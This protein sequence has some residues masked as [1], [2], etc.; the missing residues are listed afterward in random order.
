M[1]VGHWSFPKRYEGLMMEVRTT[2]NC[3]SVEL[4]CNGKVMGI[5]RTSD[6]D[7]HTIS[8]HMPYTPGTLE[9]RAYRDGKVVATKKMVTARKATKIVVNADRTHLKADGQDLAFLKITLTDDAGNPV[10]VDDRDITVEVSG[11]GRLRGIDTGET[12]RKE[13]LCSPTTSSFFGR[14]QAVVQATRQP[15][16][17]SVVVKAGGIEKSTTINLLTR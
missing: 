2:T 7:N 10:E 14:A 1:M 3:D 4:V 17:I 5:R 13:R 6:F 15:G 11:A 12:R 9:A 16:A 8:W